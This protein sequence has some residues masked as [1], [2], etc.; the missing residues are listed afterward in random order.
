V[1]VS[2][3]RSCNVL[4]Q[5]EFSVLAGAH[6]YSADCYTVL[7]THVHTVC[8]ALEAA[9]QH[10][11]ARVRCAALATLPVAAES[12]AAY[13][14]LTVDAVLQRIGDILMT[15]HILHHMLLSVLAWHVCPLMPVPLR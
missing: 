5:A 1:A 4:Q 6:P 7:H 9:V 2:C 11:S 8:R 14:R 3:L 13:G 15:H 10:A 12:V